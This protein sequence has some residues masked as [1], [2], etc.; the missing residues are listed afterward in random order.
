MSKMQPTPRRVRV[1]RNVYRRSDG[2]LEVGYRDSSGTQRWRV[3]EGG[4]MAARKI[5]DGIIGEK[6]RGQHVQPNPRLTFGQA[7]DAWLEGQVVEL[8]PR[9]QEVY[10]NA[11]ERHLRPRFGKRRMDGITTDDLARMVR[12]LRAKG[13]AERSIGGVI[14]VASRIFKFARRRLSWHGENP[15]PL[16]EAG[17]RPKATSGKRR[18]YQGGELAEM[19]EAAQG[20][21]RVLFALAAVSGARLSELLALRWQDLELTDPEAACLQI[22]EQVDRKGQRQE[23]K[24]ES[25][26]RTVELPRSLVVLLLEHKA[27][28]LHCRD[29]SLVFATRSGRALSQ[30]NVLRALRAAQKAARTP[31]G[32]PTFP[33]MHE[34]DEY[35]K[36]VPLPRGAVPTFHGFRHHFA[37]LAIS[38]GDSAE[39]VS[40]QLGHKDSAIT[41][42]V[43]L[44]EIRSEERRAKL[45]AKME[46]RHGAMLTG[47]SGSA[48]GSDGAKQPEADGTGQGAEVRSLP[49]KRS[50][51]Q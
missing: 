49:A 50:A 16:L 47:L 35:G 38:S 11:V 4:I 14:A 23:L 6:A 31:E 18:I 2:K 25:A 40:W 37:S 17:E 27:R 41:R 9:T 13:L 22:R 12:E 42:Q 5:R 32:Q 10:R 33:T 24:T 39:E 20:V 34:R 19:L 3:V 7:A 8:R 45:R 36:P 26:R 21:W 1:E 28:S 15:V 48:N 43:Y 51:A 29:G 44:Q 46:A 30:R